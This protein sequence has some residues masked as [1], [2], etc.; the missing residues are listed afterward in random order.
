MVTKRNVLKHAITVLII[1]T[2]STALAFSMREFGIRV[3][4]LLLIFIAA[5]LLINIETRSLPTGIAAGFVCVMIFNYFF[6]EPYYTFMIADPNYY[7]SMT[8]FFIVTLIANTLTSRLQHQMEFSKASERRSVL[9]NRINGLLLNAHSFLEIADFI[10]SSFHELLQRDV[11]VFLQIEQQEFTAPTSFELQSHREAVL[12]CSMHITQCGA[13][14]PAFSD[15]KYQYF[16]IR[17][18]RVAA[19]SG[20]VGIHV[21]HDRLEQKD[22]MFVDTAITSLLVACDREYSS[23]LKERATLQMEKEK[24]KS[25]LLRSI[26]HDIKT[27]L[28]SISAGS[29]LLLESYETIPSDQRVGILTDIYDESVYLADFVNN[30]LNLTKIEA[31]RLSVAKGH[32]LVEEILNEVYQRVRKRLGAHRLI[33]E[34]GPDA[35]FVDA[36]RQL[37]IQVLVNLVDNAVKHTRP[38][39]TI[40]LGCRQE[41][42]LVWFD[43]EDDGGGID[44]AILPDLFNEM[45]SV[46]DHKADKSRGTGL[47]LSLCKAV[48]DAHGGTIAA[49]NN[50][51]GGATVAFSIPVLEVGESA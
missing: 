35:L 32:E 6:V 48:V 45:A 26:S 13:G 34:N 44:P 16:P 27:P 38:D 14:T 23:L 43:V 18:K 47:G 42:A 28:T 4:N 5:V 2:V 41:H 9:L 37:L 39:C 21:G 40:R 7:V 31:N 29:S 12:W 36:D 22:A 24:F 10:Q 15:S 51:R 11:F 1:L 33:I 20:T 49:T 25:S 19:I 8:I 17:S 3:E 30:L 46:R 50:A